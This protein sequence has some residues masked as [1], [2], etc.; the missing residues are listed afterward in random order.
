[1]FKGFLSRTLGISTLK[2]VVFTVITLFG[3][4]FIHGNVPGKVYV[5]VS[6][7]LFFLN[8]FLFSEWIWNT[9]TIPPRG[10]A[11]AIVYTYIC[12]SLFSVLVWSF[13][14]DTNLFYMQSLPTHA[15]F[16]AVHALAM[17]A[18]LYERRRFASLRHFSEGLLS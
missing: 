6:Y 7:I 1:M 9:T 8:T 12:D 18:A 3:V 5:L 4:I 17:C 16:F 2:N 15:L 13:L 11:Q 10:V 14:T